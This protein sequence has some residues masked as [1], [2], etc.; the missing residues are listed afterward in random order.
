MKNSLEYYYI[1]IIIFLF[2]YGSNAYG[3]TIT[4]T[5]DSMKMLIIGNDTTMAVD[6]N[7]VIVVH[8]AKKKSWWG[9]RRYNK[10]IRNIIKVLPYAK[11]AGKIIRDTNDSLV[12]IDKKR[13]RKKYIKQR[14]KFLFSRYEKKLKKLTFSQ[15]RMLVRLID[16][17]TDQTAYTTVKEYKG[18]FSAWLWNSV[19]YLFHSSLKYSYEPN[20]RD[21]ETEHIIFMIENNLLQN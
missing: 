19:A 3:Q 5:T 17:E 15:G 8:N 11:D 20:G 13:D 7:E 12:K 10:K 1:K 21:Q 6:M 16:R 4:N 14:E 2:F 9:R 18:K